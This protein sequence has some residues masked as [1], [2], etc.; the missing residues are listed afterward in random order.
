MKLART[1]TVIALLLALTASPARAVDQYDDSQSNPLRLLA[2]V[3][4]P[5]GYLA[6]WLVLRPFH[7]I[8]SQPE[9][10]PVFGHTAHEGFDYESYTE[11]LST[12]A[13]YE[14]PYTA[15]QEPAGNY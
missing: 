14:L 12:G 3:I 9:L 2:Y 4:H 5:V 11:G 15:I 10:E 7:R 13:S 1:A 6:E 8:V